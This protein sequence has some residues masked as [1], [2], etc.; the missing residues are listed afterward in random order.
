MSFHHDEISSGF[1]VTVG[2]SLAAWDACALAFELLGLPR[3]P[4]PTALCES[5][6]AD[7]E[8]SSFH[9][10]DRPH[11]A[12]LAEM[13]NTWLMHESGPTASIGFERS[14]FG[15]F[16]VRYCVG[17]PN[18]GIFVRQRWNTAFGQEPLCR[19]RITGVLGIASQALS[20]TCERHEQG[21]WP[22]KQRLV[23]F[24]DAIGPAR[25]GWV[26]P[27]MSKVADLRADACAYTALLA[28]LNGPGCHSSQLARARRG[29][30]HRKDRRWND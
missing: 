14:A 17:L 22:R 8:A 25:W 19:R 11:A 12:G 13:A 4:L 16:A 24:D 23:L 20:I 26:G 5:L 21:T 28:E 9:T 27:A 10:P 30:S 6:V 1:G 29:A 2:P 7:E 3:P 18:I 15:I